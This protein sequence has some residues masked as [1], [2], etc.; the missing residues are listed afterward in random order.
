MPSPVYS[1]LDGNSKSMK[2]RSILA[3]AAGISATA[4]AT[5]LVPPKP[6]YAR[7]ERVLRMVT[8][9][10]RNFP[11]LGT[12]ADRLARS[13][14]A[15]SDGELTVELHPAGEL[16]PVDQMFDAVSTGA[17]EMYH[18]TEYYWEA[19]SKAFNFFA[20]VPFGMTALELDTW[21]SK[22][23]GQ[24]LWDELSGSFNIKPLPAGNTGV[25]MGGWSNKKIEAPEQ[26]KGLK[27]RI[28]GLAGEVLRN[29]GAQSVAVPP[30]DMIAA[31]KSGRIDATEW[32][33]PWSD[34]A[35]GL[36]K[37]A[38]YY[39][40][41]GFQEPG[42]MVSLG[43]NRETWDELQP[44][45][46]RLIE[47]ASHAEGQRMLADFNRKNSEA[48]FAIQKMKSVDLMRYPEKVLLAFAKASDKVIEQ[49]VK[50]D[51]IGERIHSSFM[52]T[53]TQL[54]RWMKVSDEAYLVARRLPFAYGRLPGAEARAPA[55]GATAE[56]PEAK[57]KPRPKPRTAA[58]Q[59]SPD[60]FGEN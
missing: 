19:K 35:L 9:W 29:L 36:H 26:L 48:I 24:E 25:Q 15:A 39:Y 11:G 1:R 34:R 52:E 38:R 6:A 45:H 30:S 8:A 42:T 46:R 40:W 18:A 56:K 41:P 60:P 16:I 20:S 7:A 59:T 17:V 3:G 55:N 10:P 44:R 33:G 4:V 28:P 21:L 2:R 31:L 50:D 14:T 13:I 37:A 32:L 49:S 47:L 53:R 5:A 12:S 22:M 57:P 27:I 51:D 23:G 58:V 43:I 54:A